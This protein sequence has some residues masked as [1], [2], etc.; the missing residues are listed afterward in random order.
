MSHLDAFLGDDRLQD[1]HAWLADALL[2]AVALHLLGVGV[3]RW[4]RRDELAVAQEPA[5]G[6]GD[7][8]QAGLRFWLD[9]PPALRSRRQPLSSIRPMRRRQ[10]D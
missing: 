10:R 5:G 3:M 2:A 7:W 4:R 9:R 8:A 6:D 1:I